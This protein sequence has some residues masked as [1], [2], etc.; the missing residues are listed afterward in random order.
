MWCELTHERT[1]PFLLFTIC[2]FLPFHM[3]NGYSPFTSTTETFPVSLRRNLLPVLPDSSLKYADGPLVWL[4]PPSP[5][6][7]APVS[8]KD[9]VSSGAIGLW[10]H[11][12]ACCC[13]CFE[14][15]LAHSARPLDKKFWWVAANQGMDIWRLLVF[16]FERRTGPVLPFWEPR[17]VE[18]KGY[19]EMKTARGG[20]GG[21]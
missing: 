21:W 3:N 12:W 17:E 19:G 10:L 14:W 13:L 20:K 2:P 8:L 6:S 16:F 1:Y 4:F 7:Q 15:F 5:T 18:G 9:G 11:F